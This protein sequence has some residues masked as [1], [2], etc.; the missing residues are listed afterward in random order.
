MFGLFKMRD[1][2]R[3]LA[4]GAEIAA[5]F[6]LLRREAPGAAYLFARTL[7]NARALVDHPSMSNRQKITAIQAEMYAINEEARNADAGIGEL[8]Q[9]FIE[10]LLGVAER[11]AIASYGYSVAFSDIAKAGDR[12]R[13]LEP[14]DRRPPA[15]DGSRAILTKQGRTCVGDVVDAILAERRERDGDQGQ[16]SEDVATILA[17]ASSTCG[18]YRELIEAGRRDTASTSVHDDVPRRMGSP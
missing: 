17:T 14:R 16:A 15:D 1:R 7:A 12:Y 5:S 4:A 3:D 8:A 9:R 6:E 11:D 13:S 10:R 18:G 2:E